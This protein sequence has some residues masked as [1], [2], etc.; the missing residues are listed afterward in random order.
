MLQLAPRIIWKIHSNK[1]NVP[2]CQY[3]DILG[4]A[5]TLLFSIQKKF[6]VAIK[7]SVDYLKLKTYQV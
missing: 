7:Y 1:N 4:T 6:I 2:D 5:R 3:I